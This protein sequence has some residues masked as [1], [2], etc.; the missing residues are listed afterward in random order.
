[1]TGIQPVGMYGGFGGPMPGGMPAMDHNLQFLNQL[2]GIMAPVYQIAAQAN[3]PPGFGV[4]AMPPGGSYPMGIPPGYTGPGTY[5]AQNPPSYPETSPPTGGRTTTERLTHGA[6][7]AAGTA[8]VLGALAVANIWNPGG[9]VL[10]GIA[11]G[12]GVLAAVT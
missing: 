3:M 6:T 4:G 7:A 5:P 12:V 9:W 1:M 10:G 11:L 8:A 2:N